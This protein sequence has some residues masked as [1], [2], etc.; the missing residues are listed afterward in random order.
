VNLRLP[1]TATLTTV[2]AL[3]TVA[4]FAVA[5]KAIP[6]DDATIDEVLRELNEDA[7]VQGTEESKSYR[8]VFDAYLNMTDPPMEVGEDFNMLTIHAKMDNWSAVAGWAESN[9]AMAE[10][11]RK[12]PGTTI[13]GMPYGAR[14]IE[15]T[16]RETDLMAEIAPG[17]E[18][19]KSRFPYLD[20]IDVISAYTTAEIYR[21]FE[22]GQSNE[23]IDLAASHLI[24]MR[25]L[26]DRIFLVEKR[27]SIQGLRHALSN[28][29]D[30]MYVYQDETS[31]QQYYNIGFYDVPFL[32]PGRQF[33]FMPEGDRIVSEALIKQ[34]FDRREQA[35]PERFREI[36][37]GI[38]AQ[39]R[40]LTRFGAARRWAMIAQLHGSLEASLN[41][42]Q[43]IYDDW[44]RRWRVHAYDPILDIKSQLE[45]T[46]SVRYAAVLFS[47]KD[48]SDLFAIR[49]NLI[50]DVR[51]TA[52]AAGL[53][54]YNREE[55][56]TYPNDIEKV[57]GQFSRKSV[58]ADPYDKLTQPFKYM[59]LTDEHPIDTPQGR[60]RVPRNMGVLWARGVDH[61]DDRAR[62]HTFD[63]SEGDIVYWPAIRAMQREQGLI[64]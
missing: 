59:F 8:I 25:Q 60:L 42:L 28:L 49:R 7:A 12:V 22:S 30:V 40:P 29:R 36:F 27:R 14:H 31:P 61:E 35:D 50:A 16:Y 46:N 43:L 24:L 32:R 18:L 1:T 62:T 5:A 56:G 9:A 63:G 19:R 44:W 4:W 21:R 51:G 37:A 58:D 10:A 48:I 52:L 15:S 33:L 13:F 20:A 55:F 47:M 26:C 41:R 54:A 17:N 64:D 45:N 57:Y 53:C 11:I 34:A 3:V 38:Q 2:T 23:A 6:A 39:E